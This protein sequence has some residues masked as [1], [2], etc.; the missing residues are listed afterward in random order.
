MTRSAMARILILLSGKEAK[1]HGQQQ[2]S[3]IDR[4]CCRRGL[5]FFIAPCSRNCNNHL[6]KGSTILGRTENSTN[7][8]AV[9][10]STSC[11][12]G[13]HFSPVQTLIC[14]T[15]ETFLHNP[16]MI[17]GPDDSV[18]FF[19]C[20]NYRKLFVCK[21]SDGGQTFAEP[22]ELTTFVEQ[23]RN[24]WPMTLWAISPG[25]GICLRKILHWFFRFGS[26]VVRTHTFRHVL[27]AFT[28]TILEKHGKRLR[29]CVQQIRLEIRRR[30]L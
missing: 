23:F 15:E 1:V 4:Y 5:W 7:E 2:I 16:L 19:W 10:L 12:G 13:K 25:H 9:L 29:L 27:H 20:E 11:D 18:W 22:R 28:V 6:G 30:Q 8:R 14:G 17:A 3:R 24:K 21:S 26:V